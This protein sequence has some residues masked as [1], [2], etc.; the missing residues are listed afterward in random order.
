MRTSSV[1]VRMIMFLMLM[2]V[3]LA[4][5]V[6]MG[7]MMSMFVVSNM[8]VIVMALQMN[9]KL[10][11]FDPRA[12]LAGDVEMIL[13]QGQLLKLVFELMKIH[14]EIDQ[15]AEKHIATDAAENIEIEG[16]HCISE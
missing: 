12:F 9:I 14:T 7:S 2:V 1:R 6:F 13:F 8:L 4:V 5:L 11:S 15:R 10:C 3:G 16:G